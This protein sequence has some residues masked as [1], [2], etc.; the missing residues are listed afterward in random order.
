M[1]VNI[2]TNIRTIFDKKKSSWRN[3]TKDFRLFHLTEVSNS[4]PLDGRSLGESEMKAIRSLTSVD[5]A[6]ATDG[7]MVSYI[8]GPLS[9]RGEVDALVSGLRSA[10][11]TNIRAE[12]A[13]RE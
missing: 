8:I 5:L 2:S 12:Q 6:K 1:L 7:G 3:S 10:G 9:D 13:P 11:L 4:R